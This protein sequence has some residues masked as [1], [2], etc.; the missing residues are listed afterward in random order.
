MAF[1]GNG[2][3]GILNALDNSFRREDA[4]KQSTRT[5]KKNLLSL[6]HES[7]AKN[8]KRKRAASA[9]SERVN[10]SEQYCG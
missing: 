5:K 3:T 6:P 4:V 1:R 7:R 2:L 8:E 10:P 9:P